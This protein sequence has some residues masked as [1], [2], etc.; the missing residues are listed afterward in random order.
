MIQQGG[1]RTKDPEIVDKET[2]TRH[3]VAKAK[4]DL[5]RRARF[6]IL[7]RFYTGTFA[8]LKQVVLPPRVSCRRDT[9]LIFSAIY[10][11]EENLDM[12]NQIASGSRKGNAC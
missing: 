2:S 1:T 11:P 3:L 5:H 7:P 9:V 12:L 8:A 4:F 6:L 10:A